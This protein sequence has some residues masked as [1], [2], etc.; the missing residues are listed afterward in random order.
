[1]QR[2]LLP[3]AALALTACGPRSQT[4]ARIDAALETLIPPDTLHLVGARVEEIRASPLYKLYAGRMP[5]GSMDEFVRRTGVDPRRDV[6]EVLAVNDGK[7]TLVLIRGS[8]QPAAIEKKVAAEGTPA[9][10][11]KGRT[12]L[13]TEQFAVSFLSGAIAVAGPAPLVRAT[14]DRESAR[15]AMPERLAA[16]VR[17]LPGKPQVWAVSMGKLPNL[18]LPEG[19]NFGN[20]ERAF[21]AIDT[22]VASADLSGG[23]KLAITAKYTSEAEARQVH[24]AIRGLIGLGRLTTPPDKP[25]MLRFFDT[26]ITVQE[27]SA[28]RVN[29]DIAGDLLEKV[30]RQLSLYAPGTAEPSRPGR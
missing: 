6:H 13:G 19:S 4:G 21:S 26:F 25:E 12:L 15:A 23:L 20:L 10:S 28:V 18:N 29:A 14:L 24:G 8:F 17:T 7:Q 3:I 9:L 27:G 1:M 22:A 11:H 2:L 30:V 16:L 5:A